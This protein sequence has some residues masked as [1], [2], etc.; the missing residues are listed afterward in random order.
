MQLNYLYLFLYIASAIGWLCTIMRANW[1]IEYIHNKLKLPLIF[2]WQSI[3]V[4][5]LGFSISAGLLNINGV[6]IWYQIMSGIVSG[7]LF[8]WVN[9]ILLNDAY[10]TQKVANLSLEDFNKTGEILYF[11]K[12]DNYYKVKVKSKYGNFIFNA[13]EIENRNLKPLSKVKILDKDGLILMVS[14]E[15]K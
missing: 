15:Y 14:K 10:R 9:I 5:L 8:C 1:G 7:F 12:S 4:F 2:K 6:Y 11:S 3:F 13:K